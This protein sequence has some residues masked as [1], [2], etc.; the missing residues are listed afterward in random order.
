MKSFIAT[1][2]ILMSVGLALSAFGATLE[3]LTD[4]C[5]FEIL[6]IEI[7]GGEGI[8]Q[9]GGDQAS[10]ELNVAYLPDAEPIFKIFNVC[11]TGTIILTELIT[12]T[13]DVPLTDWHEQLYVLDGDNWVPATDSDDLMW[14]NTNSQ[15]PGNTGNDPVVIPAAQVTI[16]EPTTLL[17]VYFDEP[18]LVGQTIEIHKEI[19]VPLELQNSMF[20]IVEW[21]TIEIPEP[22]SMFIAAAGLFVSRFRRRKQ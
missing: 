22:A 1:V 10:I 5:D 2:T 21:P 12:V 16:D 15:N 13:G 4:V 20:A 7:P 19:L 18:V 8:A 9:F 11:G 3:P 17:S 6:S 14:G